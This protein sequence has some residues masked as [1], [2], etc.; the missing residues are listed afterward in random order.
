MQR[1][2]T[3]HVQ[4]S[5]CGVF[6]VRESLIAEHPGAQKRLVQLTARSIDYIKSNPG[7]AAMITSRHLTYRLK[8][9]NE[10][11]KIELGY[12]EE[13]TPEM[14]IQAMERIEFTT[15]LDV[16]EIQLV[17]DSLH[18]SNNIDKPIKAR[19]ILDL[20]FLK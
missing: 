9:T 17:I 7:D 4:R 2:C 3:L 5:P 1:Y 15:L 11:E 6:A 14:C 19:D 13:V 18:R 10:A 16:K 12:Q 20:Q 8:K